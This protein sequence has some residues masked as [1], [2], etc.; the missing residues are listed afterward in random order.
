MTAIDDKF[1][2]LGGIQGFLGAPSGP[3]QS[4][5]DGIGR[6]RHFTHG[7]IYWAPKPG[8]HEVH[9]LIRDK[10]AS[11]GWER[12]FLGYPQTD[13]TP[14]PD[15]SGRFNHFQ[16]GS[17][18]WTPATSAHEVHGAI[19]G[20]WA[21]LGWER[22]G[23]GYPVSDEVSVPGGTIRC[24]QFQRG[25][26]YWIGEPDVA[27]AQ[28]DYPNIP[29]REGNLV[30]IDAGGCVQTGGA[31]KTWKRYVDP[32]GPN[33]DRL[34]HGLVQVPGVTAGLVRIASILGQPRRVPTK[35]EIT[36]P[37]YLV[38]GYEDDDY[39]DNGYWGREGDDGTGGQCRGLGNA[40][41]IVTI[42]Q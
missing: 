8:A 12:S 9:G 25:L 14:T 4:A 3:E 40:Y 42:Q 36:A 41:V 2:Q 23:L 1:A 37:M 19:R 5:P 6:Y 20:K 27:R 26:I 38:L 35:A 11:L 7:S 28:T 22:S 39:S 30:T 17:I 13:E 34:Y 10:W 15:R 33:S 31:G 32:Q 16:G 21:D 18:Y 29:I 24:S